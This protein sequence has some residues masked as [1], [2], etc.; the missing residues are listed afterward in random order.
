MKLTDTAAL[1]RAFGTFMTGVTVVTTNDPAG[2]P[3]GFTAN[4]FTSVSLNPPLVLVCP[5]KSISSFPVFQ[6]CEH[7]AINILA[8]GQEQISTTF[9][10]F[11]GDRFAQVRWDADAFGMPQISDTAAYFSC[12]RSQVIDAGD[13]VILMGEVVAAEQSGRPGLGYA[14]GQYFNLG[15]ER[16]AGKIPPV[17]TVAGAIIEHHGSVLLEDT[18]RGLR[19]PP[20]ILDQ[21]RNVRE[22]VINTYRLAGIEIELGAAFSIFDDRATGIHHIYF[23]GRAKSPDAG[24]LGAYYAIETLQDQK[25]IDEAHTAMLTRYAREHLNQRFGLYVGDD[26]I[27]DVTTL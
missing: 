19:P 13:H 15:M 14:N 17:G 7:F 3:V 20:T 21:K 9:A 25:F 16:E 23:L 24:S 6:E 2:N 11:P 18:S 8:E 5:G 12:R 1:R 4:S 22:A 27:G 26:S 10:T